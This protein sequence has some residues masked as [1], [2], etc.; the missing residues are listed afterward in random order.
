[1]FL[2]LTLSTTTEALLGHIQFPHWSE[3][4]PLPCK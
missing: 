3:S 4:K 2:S 1:M